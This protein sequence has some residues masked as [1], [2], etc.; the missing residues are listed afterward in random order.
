MLTS[1]ILCPRACR[2]NRIAGEKG[3]CQAGLLPRLGLV[4]LHHG[5]EP[6]I[7]GSKGAGTVFFSHCNLRCCFCQNSVISQDNLGR[8]ITIQRLARIF[9][10]Q[11]IRGAYT[12]DL[13]TPTHYVPQIIEALTLAKKAGFSLP[14]V[15]NSNAY[16]TTQT[17]TD[18]KGFVDI[19]LPDLKYYD[20]SYGRCYSAAPDYFLHASRAIT[21]MVDLVG[22]PIFA[23]NHI[24]L[25]GVIV[26]HLAL[27]GLVSD[28]RRI[29]DWLWHTFGNTIYISLMNQ[30]TPLYQ[31][32]MHPEINRRLTTLEYNKLIDYALKLGIKNCFIQEGRT[33][34]ADFV[35]DF[36]GD[37]VETFNLL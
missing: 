25:K 24:M 10:E 37:G 13:V 33:A 18:L 35:P 22:P 1:C 12:L 20:D 16:E 30:Y 21:K 32:K 6:C 23:A 29:L 36:N 26:R 4:C 17:L 14:V 7:A 5:E 15:Y 34:T 3:F 11:E 28:S 9:L 27:P 19:F 2:V 8:E 31:A